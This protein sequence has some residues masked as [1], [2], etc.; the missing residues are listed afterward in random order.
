MQATRKLLPGR[1]GT[2]KLLDQYGDDPL[3]V[4]YR[5]DP[6]RKIRMKTIEIIIEKAPWQGRP[7]RIPAK[8]IVSIRIEFGEVEL[9]RRVKSAG[10]TWNRERKVWEIAYGD[11]VAWGLE[12][13][14]VAEDGV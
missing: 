9:G 12:E 1:P 10:G 4:R 8:R 7:R 3:C 13:R 6:E 2:G 11:V 14:V 5:Y